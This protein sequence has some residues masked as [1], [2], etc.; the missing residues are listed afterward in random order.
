[1]G[2]MGTGHSSDAELDSIV[3][4]R[5]WLEYFDQN[6]RFEKAFTPQ[7]CEVCKRFASVDGARDWYLVE[8]G[9]AFY[10]EQI[11]Y[12]HLMIRSRWSG[13]RIGG[14][15]M[16]SVFIV[17]VPDASRLKDPFQIDMSLFVAWGMAALD[18]AQISYR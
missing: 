12:A 2:V 16:T 11:L 3:G 5:I 8:L 15:E 13:C 18:P 17:L 14:E 6:D 9:T 7:Y 1:M 10:Y 4:R